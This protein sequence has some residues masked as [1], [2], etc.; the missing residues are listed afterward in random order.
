MAAVAR[1]QCGVREVVHR[2]HREAHGRRLA[3][4]DVQLVAVVAAVMEGAPPWHVHHNELVLIL[5][6]GLTLTGAWVCV[7]MGRPLPAT[8]SCNLS[9]AHT[10]GLLALFQLRFYAA[11]ATRCPRMVWKRGVRT[12][13]VLLA[14]ADTLQTAA[15]VRHSA[16][17]AS[18]R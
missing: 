17:R 5:L 15:L 12:R 8:A 4:L 1:R 11:C 7:M 2:Q 16:R 6:V 9:V 3:S 14:S 18:V 13:F 10:A